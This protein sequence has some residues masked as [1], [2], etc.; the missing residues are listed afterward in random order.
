[1]H[2][3]S[4]LSKKPP[5]FS[6]SSLSFRGHRKGMLGSSREHDCRVHSI[7]QLTCFCRAY[8]LR[9]LLTGESRL[10]EQVSLL[11]Q[12]GGSRPA[13]GHKP[14]RKRKPIT[15]RDRGLATLVTLSAALRSGGTPLAGAAQRRLGLLPPRAHSAALCAVSAYRISLYGLYATPLRSYA[16]LRYATL[17]DDTLH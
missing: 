7:P 8:A 2:N 9:R 6:K 5:A 15:L 3:G 10:T 17:H 16:M 13:L 4:G 1:M 11:S 14:P 12:P